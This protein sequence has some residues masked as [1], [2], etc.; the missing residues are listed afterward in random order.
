MQKAQAAVEASR[1]ELD[2]LGESRGLFR[3]RGHAAAV[4]QAE[5]TLG[6]GLARLGGL[7]A[8]AARA[9]GALQ[10]VEP[11]AAEAQGRF[12]E[13]VAAGEARDAWMAEHP[14]EV[15]WM[16]DLAERVA[17]RQSELALAAEDHRPAHVLRLLG[18]PPV[19]RNARERWLDK[20]GAV[21]SYRE[22]WRVEPGQLGLDANLRGA[23]AIAWED[24]QL[25]LETVEPPTPDWL[26]WA[27]PAPDR[28]LDLG[29]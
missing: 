29:L 5:R 6:A 15:A 9:R 25:R 24:L 13:V 1:A 4:D 16:E 28:G 19:E 10:E 7:E 22:Q 8:D 12:R 17:E 18:P 14:V 20:A 26:Q 27:H 2:A 3:R 21:E 23:Q 11:V